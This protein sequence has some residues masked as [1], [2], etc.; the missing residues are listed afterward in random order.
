MEDQ[1]AFEFVSSSIKIHDILIIYIIYIYIYEN[2]Q[3][4]DD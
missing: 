1:N 3:D 4:G 2:K